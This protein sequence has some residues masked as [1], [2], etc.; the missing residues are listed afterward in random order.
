MMYE[1]ADTEYRGDI[2]VHSPQGAYLFVG[3]LTSVHSRP[4]CG[5]R[6]RPTHR[7]DLCNHSPNWPHAP[8][9]RPTRDRRIAAYYEWHNAFLV[10]ITNA[11]DARPTHYDVH[12]RPQRVGRNARPTLRPTRN[13]P[14]DIANF[15][16]YLKGYLYHW[17][18]KLPYLGN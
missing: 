17:H 1:R 5:R 9:V 14:W 7:S 16:W 3:N 2:C 10:F 13:R 4:H 12:S 11:A 15:V 8:T 6:M 18:L